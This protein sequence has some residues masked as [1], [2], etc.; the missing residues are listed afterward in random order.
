MTPVR[1]VYDY[2]AGGDDELS[3]RDGEVLQLTT[4][5]NGGQNYGDGWWEGEILLTPYSQ[6]LIL[7]RYQCPGEEG[8]L[9]K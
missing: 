6:P 5:P 8:N 1:G 3:I 7:L 2:E 4:G 9:P